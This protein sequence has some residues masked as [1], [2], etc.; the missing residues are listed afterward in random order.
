MPD[1]KPRFEVE[2][3]EGTRKRTIYKSEKDDKGKHMQFVAEEIDEPAG[4]MVYFPSG[5]SI[6]I[7]TR[8]ELERLEFA[9]PAGY[10]DM[11]S[12][13]AVEP[14]TSVSL[15]ELSRRKAKPSRA[16]KEIREETVNV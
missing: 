11:D 13:E 8:E 1:S 10:V 15:K 3:L 5:S 12:G 9:D 7:A 2:E 16:T 14:A 6:R 4:F